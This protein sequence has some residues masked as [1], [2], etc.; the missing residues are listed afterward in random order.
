MVG[1]PPPAN[2]QEVA[3]SPVFVTVLTQAGR[4]PRGQAESCGLVQVAL[5]LYHPPGEP[6]M[7]SRANGPDASVG[8]IERT[9]G[10]WVHLDPF[11]RSEPRT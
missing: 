5:G 1:M 3:R 4:P 2:A 10:M 9:V 7:R 6:P 8:L 11:T